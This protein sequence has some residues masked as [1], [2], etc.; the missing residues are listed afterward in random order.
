[1]LFRS[2]VQTGICT[3]SGYKDRAKD[4]LEYLLSESVQQT[5][6]YGGFPVNTAALEQSARRDRSEAEAETEIVA[7][8]A[9]VEFRIEAYSQ[10][11]ADK[12]TAVCA[13]LEKS[14]GEDEKIREVLTEVME[15]YLKG[16][17]SLEDTLQKAEDGLKMYLAE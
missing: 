4:F 11:T 5:D 2:M 12:L 1:M 13:G 15:G 16:G 7:D 3:K 17:Q 6:A 14:A 10:E 9:A 8:G